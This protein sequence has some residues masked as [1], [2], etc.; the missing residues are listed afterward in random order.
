M[1]E[2]TPGQIQIGRSQIDSDTYANSVDYARSTE[3]AG[4]VAYA[5]FT[6]FAV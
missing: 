6:A 4:S 3:M 5:S 1:W 2:G